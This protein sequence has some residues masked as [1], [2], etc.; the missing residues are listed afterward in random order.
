MAFWWKNDPMCRSRIRRKTC[1]NSLKYS[2]E[3]LLEVEH[4]LFSTCSLETL[5]FKKI[6]K[7]I[8]KKWNLS[9]SACYSHHKIKNKSFNKVINKI[10]WNENQK[11]KTV[12]NFHVSFISGQVLST[13]NSSWW[14]SLK[15]NCNFRKKTDWII[16]I[17][18]PA[19]NS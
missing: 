1:R 16:P 8:S 12:N 9:I 17:N 15:H 10:S 2:V 13:M 7:K 19:S 14:S 6:Q 3:I 11:K 5:T 4:K 18:S